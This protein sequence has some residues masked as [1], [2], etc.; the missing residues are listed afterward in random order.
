MLKEY[1]WNHDLIWRAILDLESR[2]KPDFSV[3]ELYEH[4]LK[5][6]GT[7]VISRTRLR[8]HLDG[9]HS[10]G[11][12]PPLPQCKDFVRE[13]KL[14]KIGEKRKLRFRIQHRREATELSET[15]LQHAGFYQWA[16]DPGI[17]P[18][19]A[20]TSPFLQTYYINF[21]SVAIPGVPLVQEKTSQVIGGI[22][23][24]FAGYMLRRIL[25]GFVND[26]DALMKSEKP[27]GYHWLGIT[28]FLLTRKRKSFPKRGL[29][30]FVNWLQLAEGEKGKYEQKILF[31]IQLDIQRIIEL[32]QSREGSRFLLDTLMTPDFRSSLKHSLADDRDVQSMSRL[33]SKRKTRVR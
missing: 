10:P 4:I 15:I 23:K 12:S 3:S 20:P 32:F 25:W 2:F 17:I 28:Q 30:R 16:Y 13:E 21:P 9:Y 22:E 6:H 24:N 19:S 8:T 5:A 14:K 27:L 1:I 7:N 11:K 31:C 33:M 26:F 29:A 18:R